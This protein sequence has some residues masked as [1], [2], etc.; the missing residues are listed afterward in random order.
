MVVAAAGRV[1]RE[2]VRA[3]TVTFCCGNFGVVLLN[4]W[5]LQD[6]AKAALD[7][8]EQM[9]TV[10]M[11]RGAQSGGVVVYHPSPSGVRN[12]SVNTRKAIRTR[13]FN[14]KR[15]DLSRL[16]R[17][18]IQQDLLSTSFRGDDSHCRPPTVFVGHTRFATSSLSTL[19]G[20]HP[21]RWTPPSSRRVYVMD[22]QQHPSAASSPPKPVSTIV[23][24]YVT[25]NGDFDFFCFPS[26]GKTYHFDTIQNG[27][28]W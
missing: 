15:T 5:W 14:R 9:I 1:R 21:H 4:H 8:L 18:K 7:T 20:T 16:L 23:E 3:T 19:E 10:T 6:R 25:H 11:M 26:E 12:V 28:R 24:N 22:R 27:C 2:N 13:I 17:R